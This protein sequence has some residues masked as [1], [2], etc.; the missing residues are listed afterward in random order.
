[1]IQRNTQVRQGAG[2]VPG[3][4]GPHQEHAQV[5]VRARPARPAPQDPC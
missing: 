1:M 4:E 5:Q 3:P 2:E